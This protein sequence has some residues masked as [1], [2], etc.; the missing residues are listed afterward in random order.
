[1]SIQQSTKIAII[2]SGRNNTILKQIMHRLS[3]DSK[4]ATIVVD[5]LAANQR[6]NHNIINL[7]KTNY[8]ETIK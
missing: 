6:V 5:D 7:L 4:D 2:G 1:M 3:K 8:N